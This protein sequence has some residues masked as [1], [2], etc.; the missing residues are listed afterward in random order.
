MAVPDHLHQVLDAD[1]KRLLCCIIQ[2]FIESDG[3]EKNGISA[4]QCMLGVFER[5]Y[6]YQSA[7]LDQKPICIGFGIVNVNVAAL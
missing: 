5:L 7:A 6:L 1:G 2:R 4:I 3:V